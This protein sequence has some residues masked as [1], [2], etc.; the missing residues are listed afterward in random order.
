MGHLLCTKGH[1]GRVAASVWHMG[2]T[3]RC[4]SDSCQTVETWLSF[5]T[6]FFLWCWRLYAKILDAKVWDW[7]DKNGPICV[8][9][10]CSVANLFISLCIYYFVMLS[11]CLLLNVFIGWI[12]TSF[13]YFVKCCVLPWLRVIL[14]DVKEKKLVGL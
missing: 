11:V 13:K 12:R 7:P 4:C 1:T 3:W 10:S 14:P 9:Q 6:T 5:C 2:A 8:W